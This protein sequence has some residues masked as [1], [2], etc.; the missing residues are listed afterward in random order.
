MFRLAR[1]CAF[2]APA[3]LLEPQ[4][5]SYTTMSQV[6]AQYKKQDG[7][8]SISKDGTMVAW[9]AANGAQSFSVAIAELESM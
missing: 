5:S 8:V 6:A 1:L 3:S 7:T 4:Q 9:Q 2:E